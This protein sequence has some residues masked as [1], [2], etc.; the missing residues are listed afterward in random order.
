MPEEVDVVLY[1]RSTNSFVSARVA[2]AMRKHGIQRVHVLAGG[3]EAWK[4]RGFSVSDR[5]ADPQAEL[6]RLGV[7]MFPPWQPLRA[8]RQ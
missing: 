5:F 3:I 6:A 1:C 4:A 8:H 2:A 7:E